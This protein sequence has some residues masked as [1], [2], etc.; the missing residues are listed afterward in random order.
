MS[1]QLIVTDIARSIEFYKKLYFEVDFLYED[2]YA[3]ISKDS[4]S[5]HLKLGKPSNEERRNKKENEH[6]DIIFSVLSAEEL[7]NDFVAKLIEITQPLCDR[8]YGREFYVADPDGYIL[9]F[10]EG[11]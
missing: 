9:A 5:I 10:L 2:F 1:P 11:K 4:Y 8:P 7:Y 3:G 6:L